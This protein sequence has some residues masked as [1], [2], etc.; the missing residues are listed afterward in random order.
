MAKYTDW[1]KHNLDQMREWAY[2]GYSHTDM[3]KKLEVGY[4]TLWTWRRKH[5]ELHAAITEGKDDRRRDNAV[6]VEDALLKRALG[7]D[8]EQTDVTE[9]LNSDGVCQSTASKVTTKHVV[10]DVSA[11]KFYLQN[12]APEEWNNAKAETDLNVGGVLVV[13]ETGGK[14]WAEQVKEQ[15]AKLAKDAKEAS[16]NAVE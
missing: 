5:P 6:K 1:V 7:Y 13:P 12:R 2:E 9:F 10:G 4:T 14:S 16:D 11:M 15:Q 3:A 8:Y